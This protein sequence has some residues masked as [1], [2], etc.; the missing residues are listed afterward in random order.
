MG[1]LGWAL[2]VLVLAPRVLVYAGKP[3]ARVHVMQHTWML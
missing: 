1:Q 2:F 3:V